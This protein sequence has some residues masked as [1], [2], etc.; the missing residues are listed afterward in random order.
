MKT[1]ISIFS[2]L[3]LVLFIGCGGSAATVNTEAEA[4]SVKKP[5]TKTKT[6]EATK[7]CCQTSKLVVKKAPCKSLEKGEKKKAAD[8]QPCTKSEKSPPVTQT[9]ATEE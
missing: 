5:C 9:K 7:P 6:V 4:S 8:V 2:A 3:S 1:L